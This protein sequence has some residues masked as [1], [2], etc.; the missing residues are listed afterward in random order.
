LNG[1]G[2]SDILFRDDGTGDFGY[3]AMNA[4]AAGARWMPV[5]GGSS[6][7]DSV[8]GVAISTATASPRPVPR[9]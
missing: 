3:E 2:T 8:L 6:S 9:Q 4:G 7:D 5:L 1:D